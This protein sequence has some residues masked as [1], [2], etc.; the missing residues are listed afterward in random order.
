MK[1]PS[2][3]QLESYYN[4][5][6]QFPLYCSQFYAYSGSYKRGKVHPWSIPY[7][8]IFYAY[9][10]SRYPGFDKPPS[11]S[12]PSP[13]GVEYLAG[14]LRVLQVVR[15]SFWLLIGLPSN[16]S[17]TPNIFVCFEAVRCSSPKILII[18]GA[19]S[20]RAPYGVAPEP[21]LN[22]RI[23]LRVTSFYFPKKLKNKS[24]MPISDSPR[25]LNQNPFCCEQPP[26]VDLELRI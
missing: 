14:R 22:R 4:T 1:N 19:R 15:A 25:A 11:Y 17:S 21:W 7:S 18:Y 26:S 6:G 20:T 8:R 16:T 3:V 23:R 24:L 12:Q 10:Q 5:I 13:V 9:K 2:R